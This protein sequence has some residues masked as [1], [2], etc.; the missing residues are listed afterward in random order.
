M[1]DPCVGADCP[2]RS[3]ELDNGGELCGCIEPPPYGN[4]ESSGV[5]ARGAIVA[6]GLREGRCRGPGPLP[7]HSCES[8]VRFDGAFFLE[9]HIMGVRASGAP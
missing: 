1:E 4:S 7:R 3:C 8:V 2:N 5:G 6:L 9:K